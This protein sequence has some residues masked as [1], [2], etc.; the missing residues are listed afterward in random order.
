MPIKIDRNALRPIKGE[1]TFSRG[2]DLPFAGVQGR[3]CGV[4]CL[5]SIGLDDTNGKR[6]WVVTD[7]CEPTSFFAA[8]VHALH[9]KDDP[10][11][12]ICHVNEDSASS[13]SKK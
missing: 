13:A 10:S 1:C 2:T 6:W 5:I 11:Y 3:F 7:Y 8:H 9:V 12:S 4:W